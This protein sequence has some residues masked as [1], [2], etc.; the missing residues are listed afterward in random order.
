MTF[1][2]SVRRNSGKHPPLADLRRLRKR[3]V[4]LMYWH[5]ALFTIYQSICQWNL[6]DAYLSLLAKQ[7]GFVNSNT[8]VG[9]AEG[10]IG[11]TSLVLS[12][13]IGI[14]V[15]SYNR[16]HLLKLT[17][18]L[19]LGA[20]L[21]TAY[22]FAYDHLTMLYTNLVL[23]GAFIGFQS[24]AAEAVFADSIEKG[25]AAQKY[26]RKG[27]LNTCGLSIGPLVMLVLFFFI[28]DKWHLRQL[29]IPLLLGCCFAPLCCIPLFLMQDPQ[30]DFGEH[31]PASLTTPLLASVRRTPLLI[32]QSPMLKR[33]RIGSHFSDFGSIEASP[34]HLPAP[35]LSPALEAAD[36]EKPKKRSFGQRSV[37]YILT[38]ADFVT[39]IGAGMSVRFFPL[40]F[41]NDYGVSP[42]QL[43]AIFCFYPLAVSLAMHACEKLS[44]QIGRA[45]ASFAFQVTGI[46][47]L[48]LMTKLKSLAWVI[49]VF[50]LRGQLQNAAYPVDRSILVDYIPSKHRGRWN[51]IGSLTTMTWSGSAVLGG[52][53]SDK[54]D[55]R[56]SFLVTAGIY[57]LGVLCYV[58][59]LWLVPRKNTEQRA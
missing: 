50:M 37:P 51:A 49:V 59:L 15:D 48:V 22:A 9:F 43:C 3:N 32:P 12:I 21:A 41:I 23:W 1:I 42:T 36:K 16:S 52:F 33:D 57:V 53:L 29:H 31:S 28:G 55:Y 7:K 27:V 35:S 24:T 2:A 58:P 39:E 26:T 47:M 56:F 30:P 11:L 5:V 20:T 44:S 34:H 17:G 10:V 19:G 13:P 18:F 14:L 38:T 6:F 54:H 45:Q 46:F 25:Q 40:F 4:T 8:W